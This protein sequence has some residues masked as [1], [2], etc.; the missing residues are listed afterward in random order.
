M[1]R[2]QIKFPTQLVISAGQQNSNAIALGKDLDGMTAFTLFGK[3]VNDNAHIFNIQLSND[4]GTSWYTLNDLTSDLIAPSN[5]KCA[6]YPNPPA[7]HLR[8]RD[9]VAA[10]GSNTWELMAEVPIY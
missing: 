9:T 8:I 4:D 6:V 7:T 1:A 3:A 5:G 10:V 2:S